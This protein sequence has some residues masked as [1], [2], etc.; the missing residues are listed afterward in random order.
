MLNRFFLLSVL[1]S[2]FGVLSCTDPEEP[3]QTPD[4]ISYF[5]EV[6]VEGTKY[7]QELKTDLPDDSTFPLVFSGGF[8]TTIDKACVPEPCITPFFIN[9]LFSDVSGKQPWDQIEMIQVP[10]GSYTSHN[11]FGGTATTPAPTTGTVTITKKSLKQ[12]LIQGSFEGEVYKTGTLT[13]VK[14]PI[15]GSFSARYL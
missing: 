8:N 10:S 1:F 9:M 14:I 12:K 4:T 3:S 15:K 2:L 13:P 11:W 5:F 6:E 7:R